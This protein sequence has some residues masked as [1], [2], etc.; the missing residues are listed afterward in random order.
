[1]SSPFAGRVALVTGAGSGIGAA[2]AR[3][4]AERGAA[5]AVFGR[6]KDK[7][8]E[9]VAQITASNGEALAIPG[10]VSLPDDLKRAVE[11]TV[12]RFGA[13]HYGVNN[14][15]MSGYFEPLH[16]LGIDQWNQ[17]LGVNLSGLFYS[18]K[19]EIPAILAAGGGAIVNVSSVFADRGG[20]TPDYSSAKHAVR[21]LTRTAAKEYAGR[22]IRVNE[23]QPGVIST[24]MT[25][26]HPEKAQEVADRGI[27]MRRVGTAREVATAIAFLLSDD[28]GYVTGAHLAV[29]GG[30]L[31]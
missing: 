11:H 18:L 9:V 2:T 22:G 19:Y 17:V 15:G 10:D 7:L 25:A 1:M 4:L 16:D 21:G 30:F 13:L 8:D 3:L 24:E 31:T 14:A 5:V 27:P 20:P 26:A 23:L 6:R 28:A 12:E 29:D